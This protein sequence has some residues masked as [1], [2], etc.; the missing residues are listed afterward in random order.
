MERLDMFIQHVWGHTA[1][2]CSR[3]R[4]LL[5]T[6]FQ[7]Q[8]KSHPV[9]PG[10][11]KTVHDVLLAA[12]SI[13]MEYL[14]HLPAIVALINEEIGRN[15]SFASFLKVSCLYDAI[16]IYLNRPQAQC[17]PH[18]DAPDTEL[19]ELIKRP[20][21]RLQCYESLFKKML[22][23]ASPDHADVVI[24]SQALETLKTVSLQADHEVAST[25]QQKDL[26][27]YHRRLVFDELSDKIVSHPVG[28]DTNMA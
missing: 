17:G 9:I 12:S 16:H 1:Q 27:S 14:S 2:L 22:N 21:T 28:A 25:T 20:A 24:I 13:Y 8:Q 5:D 3:H 11:M 10:I 19:K 6:L 7:Y 18:A 15:T 4:E 26:A 23:Q